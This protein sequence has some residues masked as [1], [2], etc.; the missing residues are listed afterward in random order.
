MNGL[1][2]S[3]K[4]LYPPVQFPV[5]SGTPMISPL[6]HWDHSADWYV[7]YFSREHGFKSSKRQITVNFE[8][9]EFN[10]IL[11]YKVDG[12]LI[13]PAMGFIFTIWETFSIFNGKAFFETDVEFSDIR[14]LTDLDFTSESEKN[15]TIII[16]PGTG[17]F[18]VTR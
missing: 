13:F 18:E 7:P 12:N 3:I 8:L 16:Q 9:P 15:L 17:F 6:I 5:S 14:F 1:D 2:F 11:D 4:N 10:F